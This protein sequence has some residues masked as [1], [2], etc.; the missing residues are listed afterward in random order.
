MRPQGNPYTTKAAN[1]KFIPPWLYMTKTRSPCQ[2][3]AW[4]TFAHLLA[5]REITGIR[6]VRHGPPSGVYGRL[7]HESTDRNR[8]TPAACMGLHASIFVCMLIFSAIALFDEQITS[9][10]AIDNIGN[11]LASR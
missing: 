2:L 4:M 1:P 10:Q 5:T 3:S 11:I 6:R 9:L 8:S 7:A